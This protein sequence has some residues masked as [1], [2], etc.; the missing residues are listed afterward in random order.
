MKTKNETKTTT[1]EVPAKAKAKRTK[2]DHTFFLY[3]DGKGFI[4]PGENGMPVVG[5]KKPT[6]FSVRSKA[7]YAAEFFKQIGVAD[8]ITLFMN[9]G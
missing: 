5:W 3:V 7:A 2:K 8:D 4:C 9:I 1:V 6:S